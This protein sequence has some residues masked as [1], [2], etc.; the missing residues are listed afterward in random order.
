[1]I[2]M[3]RKFASFLIRRIPVNPLISAAQFDENKVWAT[4]NGE[5][6][7]FHPS[8]APAHRSLSK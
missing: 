2:G 4:A 8:S 7:A 3:S 6:T 1:M 5:A